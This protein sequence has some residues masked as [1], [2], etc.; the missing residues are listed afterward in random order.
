[1]LV[2]DDLL[3]R[4]NTSSAKPLRIGNKDFRIAAVLVREPDRM[5]AT[6]SLGPRVLISRGGLERYRLATGGQPLGRTH[7]F[8]AACNGSRRAGAQAD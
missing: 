7:A 6:M 8:Q 1:M 4:L 5:S 3:V 2:V